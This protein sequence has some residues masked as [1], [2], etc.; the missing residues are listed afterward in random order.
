MV[1]TFTNKTGF[2]IPVF[3]FTSRLLSLNAARLVSRLVSLNAARPVT[4][5]VTQSTMKCTR[6]VKNIFHKAYS[7]VRRPINQRTATKNSN[8]NKKVTT[9]KVNKIQVSNGLGP[10]KKLSF[11]FDV[12]G[13]PQQALQNKGTSKG[14]KISGKGKIMTGKL[15][16][17]D[18]YFVK[19]LKFNLFSISQMVSRENNM[20]NVDLKNVVPSGVVVEN[21][22]N[23]N[24]GI[25]ENLDAGKVGKETVSAQQYVLLPLWSFD[26]QDSKNIDDD[27]SD[28]AFEIKENE[29]FMFLQMKVPRLIKRNMMKKA[30]R[31]DKG[32]SPVDLI[33]RVRDL[34][35]EFEEFSFNSTNRLNAVSE[36]VNAVGPN[37][38][39]ST[40]NF[41]T[42]SPSVTTVSLNFG[43][44][45]KSSFVDP[46]KYPD[47]LD[48]PELEEIVYSDNEEE[49][50][51]EADLSNLETNIHVSP[52]LTT[53]V[54]KEHH[55]NQIIEPKKVLQTLKDPSWIE[56]MQEELL[57]FKLQ[58]VW[59]LVDLPKGKRAI[60]HTQEEGI[61]YDEFFAPV[62][63]IEAIRLVFSLCFLDG[64]HGISDGCQKCFFMDF[65]T[66]N[67]LTG[68][69]VLS[70]IGTDLVKTVFGTMFLFELGAS[71]SFLNWNSPS[72][73]LY[74]HAILIPGCPTLPCKV[75]FLMTVE[76]LHLEIVKPN[77]FFVGHV[78]LPSSI[79]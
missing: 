36:P 37:R 40:N 76:T 28:D 7:P 25:K 5:D 12:H 21:Q 26:S 16:V 41:N 42:A 8:F 52:I 22:P 74:I 31:D 64:F 34:R 17:D 15:N 24:A 68:L 62:A 2:L 3:L 35:V 61:D 9:V 53:R 30:N 77:S 72:G 27:V 43:I 57:Q 32:K 23:D 49:V 71:F 39:N 78:Q 6:P 56:A 63:R 44:A 50:G 18:V 14:G 38:T 75:S 60:G 79:L 54:H 66:H 59:V 47:D 70:E 1:E 33:T 19:E 20:Y 73:R 65:P 46:S 29:M 51:A 48:M 58:K 45:G 10:Q 13:N 69:A 4:T 55:V 67:V 11:L